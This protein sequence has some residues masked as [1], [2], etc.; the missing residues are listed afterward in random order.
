M[1]MLSDWLWS[2]KAPRSA[3]ILMTMRCGISQTVLYN[4][5]ISSGIPSMSCWHSNKEYL[6][7]SSLD[8]TMD[9]SYLDGTIIRYDTIFHVFI[10]Q[11][12]FGKIAKYMVIHNLK[13]R[14]KISHLFKSINF[15]KV[16]E[17]L[18]TG[19]GEHK[20]WMCRPQSIRCCPKSAQSKQWA[21]EPTTKNYEVHAEQFYSSVHPSPRGQ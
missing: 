15:K 14:R 1:W 13:L 12:S 18:P 2:M 21:W 3:A 5:F 7:K 11:T 16:L 17:I 20:C 4:A 19:H 8:L 10:P 9:P 6:N